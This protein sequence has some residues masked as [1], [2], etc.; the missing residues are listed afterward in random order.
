MKISNFQF[1]ISKK[2]TVPCTSSSLSLR[3][4]G[5]S[6]VTSQKGASLLELTIA[7]GIATMIISGLTITTLVS[8]KNSQ[9]A[10]NQLQATKLAQEGLDLIS[11][12][13]SKN[14]VVNAAA[15]SPTPPYYW[16]GSG[17][18]LIWAANYSTAVN[19]TVDINSPTCSVS[20]GQQ[21]NI[22]NQFNRTV[23]IIDNG[24]TSSKKITSTVSWTDIS[25]S[26]QSQLV[27]IMT[28]H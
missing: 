11:T 27:T 5:L 13:R 10:E 16:Y 9:F 8:L 3:A 2:P 4:E 6:P 1:P 14:C 23:S 20:Q 15:T 28:D 24:S 26:H 17:V 7:L 25:G 18:N 21:T 22:F 19:V 12:A